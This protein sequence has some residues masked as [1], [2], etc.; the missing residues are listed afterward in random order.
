MEDKIDNLAFLALKLCPDAQNKVDYYK[1]LADYCCI[2]VMA[3]ITSDFNE[4]ISKPGGASIVLLR[5]E[6]IK[7]EQLLK[8]NKD[9]ETI[10]KIEE[11]QEKYA[12][13]LSAFLEKNQHHKGL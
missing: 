8:Y 7:L 4:I 1:Q 13:Q 2:N 12:K 5:I 11:Y 6:I 10:S 9:M 3:P